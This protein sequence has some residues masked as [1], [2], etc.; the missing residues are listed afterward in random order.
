MRF[1]ERIRKRKAIGGYVR[2]LEN[3]PDYSLKSTG[4]ERN[5]RPH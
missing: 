4:A 1:F 5:I 3:F 2:K